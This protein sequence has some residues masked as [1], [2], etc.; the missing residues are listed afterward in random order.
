MNPLL[1]WWT[2]VVCQT[3][4][5]HINSRAEFTLLCFLMKLNLSESRGRTWTNW[6]TTVQYLQRKYNFIKVGMVLF[7]VQSVPI[8]LCLNLGVSWPPAADPSHWCLLAAER[9]SLHVRRP[10]P[11][12]RPS[13]WVAHAPHFPESPAM[14]EVFGS[15]QP[16]P[17]S[18][19][20]WMPA[21]VPD[22]RG[23]GEEMDGRTIVWIRKERK[24]EGSEWVQSGW[25]YEQKILLKQQEISNYHWALK[26]TFVQGSF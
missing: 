13:F 23:Q 1:P 19:I 15:A 4:E 26:G 18:G 20:L 21:A 14:P 2:Q 22:T 24:G 7:E 11:D 9:I 17:M 6:F 8:V 5:K 10:L 3:N 16:N 25:V 12:I